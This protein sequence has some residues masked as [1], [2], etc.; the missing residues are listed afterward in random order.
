MA[1]MKKPSKK[2][3][4]GSKKNKNGS[5]LEPN[6]ELSFGGVKYEEGGSYPTYKKDSDKAKSFREAFASARK[7]GKTTF[8]W[9][10]RK[11]GTRRADENKEQHSAAMKKAAGSSEPKSKAPAPGTKPPGTPKKEAP[12]RTT[13]TGG[14]GM[15][16]NEREKALR[17][18]IDSAKPKPAPKKTSNANALLSSSEFQ[19]AKK[20]AKSPNSAGTVSKFFG[21]K[22]PEDGAAKRNKRN[23]A[24]VKAESKKVAEAKK[25]DSSKRS[26]L[27]DRRVAKKE[28]KASKKVVSAKSA[29]Q[30]ITD[31]INRQA[32]R[33]DRKIERVAA[34]NERRLDRTA[35]RYDRKIDPNTGISKREMNKGARKTD[36]LKKRVGKLQGKMQAGGLK[37]PSEDQKG[38][39]KLPT[40]VR[41]KMGYK[42]SGGKR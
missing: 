39:K 28:A 5:F 2:M 20:A 12:A 29:T 6:K 33:K 37:A 1:Y 18:E 9:D 3:Y 27:T 36:R 30:K 8:E 19:S 42:K 41:N 7:S 40:S 15:G 13:R 23:A 14:S 26:S 34:K 35:A 4:G 32:P 38:L 16:A 10:G 21:A 31:K 11:Y 25:G 17:A 24:S 22:S